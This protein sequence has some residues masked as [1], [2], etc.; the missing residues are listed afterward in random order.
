MEIQI[1][2]GKYGK[3]C[4]YSGVGKWGECKEMNQGSEWKVDHIKLQNHKDFGINKRD[5]KS[6]EGFEQRRDMT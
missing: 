2:K 5:E 6:L 4:G 1:F 3:Q